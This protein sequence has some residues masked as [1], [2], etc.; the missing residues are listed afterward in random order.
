MKNSSPRIEGE[1]VRPQ[2]RITD[3]VVREL[4]DEELVY[5]LKTHQ[6]Y[7]LSKSAAAVWKQC[8]GVQTMTEIAEVLS[9]DSQAVIDEDS[10]LS[11]LHQLNRASLFEREITLPSNSG[12][13]SRRQALR[14]LGLGAAATLPLVISVVAPAAAQAASCVSTGTTGNCTV[15]GGNNCCSTCCNNSTN[16]CLP[17]GISIGQSCQRDCQCVSNKC[18]SATPRVCVA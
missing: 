10:I 2:A 14:Q 9:R 16:V 18:P 17:T 1:E 15:A 12:R 3:L 6:A 4:P 11:A 7:C 8:D 5:D 13:F